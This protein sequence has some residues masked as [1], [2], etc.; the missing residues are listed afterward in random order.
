MSEFDPSYFERLA[1]LE[2]SERC[3]GIVGPK[4]SRDR[5]RTYYALFS[6]WLRLICRIG[7]PAASGSNMLIRRRA[8]FDAGGFDTRLSCNEDSMLMWKVRR[9]GYDVVY[10]KELRVYETDHGRL[11]NGV[12]HKTA[13]SICRC[14]ALFSGLLPVE[15]GSNDWGYWKRG[16]TKAPP[17]DAPREDRFTYN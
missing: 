13:H 10:G 17:G 9:S 8:L 7:F 1:M 12:F 15:S 16:R 11:D 6:L 5:Y 2:P 3:G 4:C 14:I